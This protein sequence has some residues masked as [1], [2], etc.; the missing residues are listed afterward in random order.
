[1][2]KRIYVE[3]KPSFA[4]ESSYLLSELRDLLGIK[5][6]TALRIV[7][8][9]DVEGLEDELFAMAVRTVFS[10]PQVDDTYAAIK[11]DEGDTVFAAEYLPGQF[12]M[13]ASSA[14][15]CI[16]LISKGTK[17]E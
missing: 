2:V 14:E 7:N 12:D 17:R 10:E 1:M 11:A 9:Y 6:L 15:E 5:Q 8:R 13:R 16:Q 3:K 4:N